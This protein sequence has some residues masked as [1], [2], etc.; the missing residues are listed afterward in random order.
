MATVAR[1]GPANGSRGDGTAAKRFSDIP[2]AIDIPVRDQEDEA[3]E[4]DLDE[5]I[6][7]PTELCTLLENEQ[8]ARI[9]WM[10]VAMAYAKKNKADHA[11]EML[12]R[13]GQVLQTS[14]PREKVSM[15]CGLC[16]LYLYKA[17]EAPRVAPSGTQPGEVKTKEYFLNQAT[18]SLNEALRINPAFPPLFLARGVLLLLQAS[19]QSPTKGTSASE[20][21]DLLQ[22]A[23]KSFD[24]ALRVS[25]QKNMMA[26]MGKGRTL[27]SMG[28][29]AQALT[30]Y[31]Q[32]LQKM[33]SLTD[34]DP[35]IGIGCC[36]W[37]LG[38]KDDAKAAWER[39]LEVSP[40]KWANSL[41]GIYYLD[42]SGRV[43]A[44]SAEF[45]RLYKKA[46]TEYTQTAFKLDKNLP[47]TCST[48]ANYFLTR[49]NFANA[50]SLAHKAIQYTDINA[51]A[52]DGWYLLAKKEH[53]NNNLSLSSD[54]YR[55]ADEARGGG[56]R[57]YLPAKFG[58]A[59]IAVMRNDLGEA[60]LRLEKMIQQS[61]S[62][63]AMVLLGTIYAEEVFANEAAETKEDKSQEAKKAIHYL[64]LVR[65]A[66]KDPKRNVQVDP[67][68]LLNLARLYESESPENSL[69]CL[70]Q[71]EAFEMEQIPSSQKPEPK[72]VYESEN[73]TEEEIRLVKQKEDARVLNEIH[74]QLP[75]QLLNNV[76]CFLEQA[77]KHT[78]ACD[79]FQAAM[80]ACLKINEKTPEADTDGL[81]TTIS[82]NLA[83]SYE[84]QGMTD[85]AIK[86]YEGILSRHPGYTDAQTRLAYIKLRQFPHKEGP[87]AISKLYQENPADLE[88][89]ALYGWYLG[90]VSRK[91][92]ANI[93]EDMEFRHFKHTLQNYDK[94]D[95]YA[96]IGMG[97]LYL[98]Q[99]REMRRD[100]EQDKQKRSA[101]YSK[102]LEFF[103]KALALDPKN[104]FAATGIAIALVEDKKDLKSALPIFIK[105]RETIKDQP[106][107][108]I[109]LG[110]IYTDLRQFNKA[111]ENYEMA[112]SKEGKENDSVI[113]SCLGRVLMHRG[114]SE[115][116]L[117]SFTRALECAKKALASA[118][119]QVHLRF[120]VAFV[121]VQLA[122][123]I[124]GLGEKMRTCAQLQQASEGLEEAIK[125]LEEIATLPNLPYPKSDIEQR[126]NMARNTQRKQLER[127]LAVQVEYES[128]NAEKLR[129]A[130][131]K[132]EEEQRR[133]EEARNAEIALEEARK[134]R[135]RQERL[136]LSQRDKE[137]ADEMAEKERQIQEAEMTSD[138]EGGRVKRKR[139]S[140]P[141]NDRGSKPRRSKKAAASSDSESDN[142]GGSDEEQ[143]APKTKKRKLAPKAAPKPKDNGKFKSAEII[144]DSSDSDA[145]DNMSFR[146][147]ESEDELEKAERRLATEANKIDRSD[148]G[149]SRAGSP[150][151][152]EKMD[153]DDE[154]DE[155][156]RPSAKRRRGRVVDDED[157]DEES[158]GNAAADTSMADEA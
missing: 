95:R 114:R 2:S 66:W 16:F 41:L 57:G 8:A 127:A 68:A 78:Q 73:P 37:Q 39:S 120:N 17:R 91:R 99:A 124:H 4:V 74:S 136:L 122:A 67:S 110:H 70:L 108:Y 143:A 107:P 9:Y 18:A 55:R 48:F 146:G 93:N 98:M 33:P 77:E 101:I 43:P 128:R 30:C 104:A 83:R 59:Q 69:Q 50:D 130:N 89:R 27:F 106:H 61:R 79:M 145:D 80:G 23:L 51:I 49:K 24:E 36:F 63:E 156:S 40:N 52:S 153:V 111:I 38:F 19:L 113:L 45:L 137:M 116:D 148:V 140:A 92:P 72:Y 25:G 13:A 7:D 14:S 56:D 147:D 22:S 109:N 21:D 29:Y 121:Q 60:K 155:V 53:Y 44:N 47:L 20:R 117:D 82:F 133:K 6:D 71:V 87:D 86:M 138:G 134:E 141:R 96:L 158:G 84:F 62:I 65:K 129:I 152:A 150:A 105:V 76:G 118:P 64:E 35:R 12:V 46:M 154:D 100:T 94:H 135:V 97:N 85:E 149:S 88:V 42:A 151:I 126:A 81:A 142:L 125:T 90:K 123:T 32:V 31:Q 112:L 75:P 15:T 119:E 144:D 11:I 34:P 157:S 54:Y 28:K 3:V 10:T 131:K 115:R 5:L 102:A 139:K 103:D 26:M 58:A 132:R 1:N